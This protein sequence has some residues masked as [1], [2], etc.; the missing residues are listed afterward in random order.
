MSGP[1]DNGRARQRCD[2]TVGAVIAGNPA[3]FRRP[4]GP[5]LA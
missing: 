3:R 5:D 1:D 2:E 4:P